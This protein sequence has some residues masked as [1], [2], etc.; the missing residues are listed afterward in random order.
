MLIYHHAFDIYHCIFR[1]LRLLVKLPRNPHDIEQLRILDFYLLF[2]DQL[3]EVTFPKEARIY[4]NCSFVKNR[5]YEEIDDPYRVFLQMEAFQK[6]ALNCL[7]SYGIIGAG[8]LSDGKIYLT[9]KKLPNE[10]EDALVVSNLE[11]RE[12]ID[13]LTGPLFDLDFY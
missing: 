5:S 10:L 12:L 6:E 8:E 4:R 7:A 2:P 1:M 11:S 3:A 9:D 13:L